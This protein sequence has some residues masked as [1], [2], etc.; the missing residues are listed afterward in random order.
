MNTMKRLFK[1]EKISNELKRVLAVVIFT[2]IY[3]IGMAWFIDIAFDQIGGNDVRLYTGGIPGILQVVSDFFNKF[4]SD[5][6]FTLGRSFI[7]IGSII[8]N[9][10]VLI[11][12]WIGVS[13]RF[14]IYSLISILIQSTVLGL[15]PI[16]NMGLSSDPLASAVI[17]G[18]LIGVGVGGALKFGTSTGGFDIVA[19]YYSLR[20]GK[21]VGSI[22]LMLNL[23]I[24]LAGGIILQSPIIVSYTIIRIVISTIVTDRFHTSYQYVSFNII[25]NNATDIVNNLLSN[26][27]RGIT[28]INV[29][30]AYSHLEKKMI[31]IVI[32]SYERSKL[33][34]LCKKSDP[35][36]FI[37]EI[38]TKNVYG[39]FV[40]K[41]IA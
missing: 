8:L 22:S 13:H 25:T 23:T 18:M 16:V 12:G 29:E 34:N 15:I 31:Y 6:N 4:I 20:K 24:A 9:I 2:S 1:N 26:L 3:G 28:L 27:Y 19:Q 14:T 37:V 35:T 33:I 32:S 40:K 39:N 17:G 7:A 41:T 5:G 21:S 38:P 30:G 10:P 36:C 11:L